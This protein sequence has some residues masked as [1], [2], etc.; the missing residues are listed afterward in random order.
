MPAI[1]LAQHSESR[2]KPWRLSNESICV[3]METGV[4]R[5]RILIR[6][7]PKP[8]QASPSLRSR[9]TENYYSEGNFESNQGGYP[10]I[11]SVAYCP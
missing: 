6:V 11:D 10:N 5:V 2:M 9:I 1:D 4:L 8:E 7:D 3:D